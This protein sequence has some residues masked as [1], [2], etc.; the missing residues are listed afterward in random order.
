MPKVSIEK[1]LERVA[2]LYRD[3]GLDKRNAEVIAGII[4]DAEAAG[5]GTHGLIRVGPQL[6]QLRS[7]GHRD[8]AWL[9]DQPGWALYD[10]RDGLG[11]LVANTLADKA[12]TM[13]DSN[14]MSLVGC[15]GATHSG[16]MGYYARKV[17][18][19][20]YIS[21]WFANCSPLSAPWG[22]TSPVLGTNP[23]AVGLPHSPEP[24]VTDMATTATTYGDCSVAISEG[25]EIEPG[26]ALDSSGNPTTDPL[27]AIRGG[28]LLPLGEHKG[29][30][31]SVAVQLL[32]TALTGATAVPPSLSDYG[33]L[34]IALRRD[35]LVDADTYDSKSS[36]LER[37]VKAA[38]V[39]D[40]ESPALLPGERSAANRSRSA[41]EG[42]EIS[43][44][45]YE[46]LFSR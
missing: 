35:I 12:I 21:L 42:I 25:R 3:A 10:G 24:I 5:R 43:D 13:L 29:Y 45:L 30:A 33:I 2:F 22:A 11:Y 28:C 46:E 4:V 20:G 6:K 36:E 14:P 9:V 37:A 32:S 44:S 18:L 7:R 16:P 15:R 17:A 23:V 31:L 38:R 1:L 19:E 39:E 40:R 27:E 26:R 41:T 8:G 34:V